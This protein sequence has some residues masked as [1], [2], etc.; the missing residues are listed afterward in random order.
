MAI[1]VFQN[2][3]L[4]CV[5]AKF[6]GIFEGGMIL[7]ELLNNALEFFCAG[8][9]GVH[10]SLQ[11]RVSD[12]KRLSTPKL[13]EAGNMTH[14]WDEFMNKEE[15]M[16][17]T[18][19]GEGLCMLAMNHVASAASNDYIIWIRML[20]NIPRYL[21]LRA[22]LLCF[23]TETTQSFENDQMEAIARLHVFP[24]E[25]MYQVVINLLLEERG[26][27]PL[28][29][30]HGFGDAMTKSCVIY[31]KQLHRMDNGVRGKE[32]CNCIGRNTVATNPEEGQQL[33]RFDEFDQQGNEATV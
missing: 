21:R 2:I 3:L 14:T 15:I 1:A 18:N 4:I 28:E 10:G 11:D 22:L 20:H 7:P 31:F 29:Y 17:L 9:L 33:Q 23:A 6:M 16:R 12:H 30:T 13:E 26:F 25:V 27:T 32:L 5:L 24:F 19:D 8:F